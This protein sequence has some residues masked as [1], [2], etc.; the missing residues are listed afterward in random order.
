VANRGCSE[1]EA[2]R[3]GDG[4][5]ALALTLVRAVGRLS[6]D[7]LGL[8]PGHAG[9]PL[10][11]PGA[12]VPGPHRVELSW[13]LHAPEDPLRTAEA[14]RFAV[15]ALAFAGEQSAAAPSGDALGDGLRDGARLL[16][17]D[18][19][20]VLVSAIEPPGDRT[21]RSGRAPIARVYNASPKPR[22]VRVR[23]NGAGA[24][25]LRVVDLAGRPAGDAGLEPGADGAVTLALRGWQLVGLTPL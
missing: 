23:W 3:E 1:V 9:P 11:T 14:H 24:R 16:E 5:T 12:Q 22:R 21:D 7:D 19:P 8:R 4:S 10:E 15:P 2:L 20:A 6:R 13:R 25:G 18:D 17:V